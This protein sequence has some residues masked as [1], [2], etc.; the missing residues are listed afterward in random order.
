M[1]GLK[2]FEDILLFLVSTSTPDCNPASTAFLD[3]LLSFALGT[4][5]LANVVGL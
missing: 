5:D 1:K 3:D 2:V 4:D